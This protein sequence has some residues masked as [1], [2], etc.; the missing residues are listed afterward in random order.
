VAT[1]LFADLKG[2]TQAIS[3]IDAEAAML[4]IRPLISAMAAAVR[5]HGGTVIE[6]RGDG[7][8]SGFGALDSLD[9]HALA[10]CRAALAIR[11]SAKGS[12]PTNLPVR[13][14][15]HT[16]EV[17]VSPGEAGNSMIGATVH[18]ASRLEQAAEPNTILLSEAVYQAVS[19]AAEVQPRGRFTFKGF[20]RPV[21]TWELIDI[22]HRSRWTHRASLGLT[23]YCGRLSER[24][25]LKSFVE[26]TKEATGRGTLC[27]VGDPGTGKSR[28]I[29]DSMGSGLLAGCTVWLAESELPAR[30]SP[31]AIARSIARRWL[32]L[33][34]HNT[35]LDVERRLSAIL[36]QFGESLSAHAPALKAL[37]NLNVTDTDWT[38]FDLIDRKKRLA[39]AFLEVCR[40]QIRYR[41]LFIV[42]DDAQWCDI[43]TLQLLAE[44]VQQ[45]HSVRSG[46][47]LL[48]RQDGEEPLLEIF[49]NAASIRLRELSNS[50]TQ[51]FL[52]V[53]LGTHPSL[54]PIK[55]KLCELTGG[56]PFFLEESI[57]YLV[58]NGILLG[59]RGNY[60]VAAMVDTLNIPETVEALVSSRISSLPPEVWSVL[61]VASVVGRTAPL[62]LIARVCDSTVPQLQPKLQDLE[63]QHIISVSEQRS[64]PIF[65][66]RH[67]FFRQVAYGMTLSSTR[68]ALHAKTL[69]VA[70]VLFASRVPD[71]ISFLVYHATLASL[72]A[73]AARY[74]RIAAEHA[75]LASSYSAASEFCEQAVRHLEMLPQT[76]ENIQASIDTRLLLRVAAGATSDFQRWLHHL[77]KAIELAEQIGDTPRR[78]LALIHRTWALNF[79]SSAFDAVRAGEEAV[80]F[81]QAQRIH[82]SE[83]LARFALAQALFASGAYRSAA[84]TLVS[85]I[86]WLSQGHETQQFGTTGTTLVLC[87]M[88]EANAYAAMGLFPVAEKKLVR[89]EDL[90]NATRRAYDQVALSYCRGMVWGGEGKIEP[91]INA[92]EN[93]FELCHKHGVNLF[94]PL[95]SASLAHLLLAVRQVSRA[96][97]VAFAGHDVAEKL[98]HNIARSAAA[99]ALAAVRLAQGDHRESIRLASEARSAAKAHGH[100]GV[101]IAATRTLA[102][103][104][105]T[106][107]PND[108]ERPIFLLQDAIDI[109]ETVQALPAIAACGLLLVAFLRKAGR[110]PEAIAACRRLVQLSL[111]QEPIPQVHKL[112]ALLRELGEE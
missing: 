20:E 37:L 59:E 67:E 58:R 41:P 99:T 53:L 64:D 24:A 44:F 5:E 98:G 10:A 11:Q 48:A 32:G 96:S 45:A 15:I 3:A 51:D 28:F 42:I 88:M 6:V 83:M 7:I 49:P 31:Y 61:S 100:R 25:L 40:L 26:Q 12:S 29:H 72:H 9:D 84:E 112:Q 46:L 78:L 14:G 92:L 87:I 8:L 62:S 89:L 4:R 109:G 35:P 13:I 55:N 111:S 30:H 107:N 70:E 21:A 47:I 80:G 23:P 82:T 68:I 57:R 97:D 65:E 19:G 39:S 43:E 33:T 73:D 16:G 27:V 17:I 54:G 75:V 103:A 81:A 106:S 101:E 22:E 56:L 110:L 36:L 1:V 102:Q 63:Q 104:F 93:G 85:V 18:L 69:R 108:L 50:D 90:A 79:S 71:W 38:T 60:S 74:S 76:K 52:T 2:S 95:I 91:A 105:A 94:L 77:S 86:A 66:F 34:E